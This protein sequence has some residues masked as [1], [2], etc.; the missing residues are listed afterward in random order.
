M[1]RIV[2]AHM[3]A[4]M[5]LHMAMARKQNLLRNRFPRRWITIRTRVL[6]ANRWLILSDL[7]G[8]SNSL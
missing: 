1:S 8:N 3:V 5:F 2:V 6:Y 4:I 7:H